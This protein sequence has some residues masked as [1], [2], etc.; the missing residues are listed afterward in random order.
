M[1]FHF[2]IMSSNFVLLS[3][4][5]PCDSFGPKCISECFQNNG[6]YLFLCANHLKQFMLE[7]KQWHLSK[8]GRLIKSPAPETLSICTNCGSKDPNCDCT[9]PDCSLDRNDCEC[10]FRDVKEE[11]GDDAKIPYQPSER[12]AVFSDEDI[13]EVIETEHHVFYKP[14]LQGGSPTSSICVDCIMDPNECGCGNCQPFPIYAPLPIPRNH[15]NPCGCI[16]CVSLGRKGAPVRSLT[17]Q[18]KY[19]KT[20]IRHYA[21]WDLDNLEPYS[22]VIKMEEDNIEEVKSYSIVSPASITG[23][24]QFISY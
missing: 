7:T 22:P 15:P 23:R 19:P 20:D 2:S 21:T 10:E 14:G 5:G 11:A 8:S 13:D 24:V 17:F 4:Q 1:H 12:P 6:R 9:C 18:D 3:R 16:A